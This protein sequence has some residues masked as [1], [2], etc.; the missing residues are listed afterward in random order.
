MVSW[1]TFLLISHNP[2]YNNLILTNCT[3]NGLNFFKALA[4]RGL[5]PLT[6]TRGSAPWI[7]GGGHTPR[8]PSWPYHFWIRSDAPGLCISFA[9][10]WSSSIIYNWVGWAC[11]TEILF[12]SPWLSLH[13]KVFTKIAQFCFKNTKF[14]SFCRPCLR[15]QHSSQTCACKTKNRGSCSDKSH[16]N[17]GHL[18]T[19]FS[20]SSRFGVFEWK[21]SKI[22]DS[23]ERIIEDFGRQFLVKQGFLADVRGGNKKVWQSVHTI[24]YMWVIPLWSGILCLELGPG[25]T[26]CDWIS[27]CMLGY[28]WSQVYGQTQFIEPLHQPFYWK[29]KSYSLNSNMFV[30][31]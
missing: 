5:R 27:P 9:L 7:P 15:E 10:Q 24:V 20:N 28:S 8:P 3:N 11:R 4:S 17:R 2:F 19:F 31:W 12:S 25:P 18:G 14:S 22:L 16:K 23:V 29:V 26:G 30:R 13:L 6:P 21:I 1:T